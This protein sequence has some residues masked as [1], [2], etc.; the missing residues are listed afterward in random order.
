VGK[1]FYTSV[2]GR[3]KHVTQKQLLFLSF[4]TDP[5][6]DT[7]DNAFRSGLKAGYTESTAQRLKHEDHIKDLLQEQRDSIY[8]ISQDAEAR[9][10]RILAQAEIN[11]EEYVT[12]TPQDKTDK[13]I[14]ADMTKFSAERLAKAH[15]STRTES[16]VDDNE[17][18][19]RGDRASIIE[20]TFSRYL[21]PSDESDAPRTIEAPISEETEHDVTDTVEEATS[22]KTEHE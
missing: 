16:V 10:A 4:Y 15:Y 19:V 9:R 17:G 1:S 22:D 18:F 14:K 8:T 21:A 3:R 2:K 13:T 7:F 5:A 11:L 12:S 6:S 20:G